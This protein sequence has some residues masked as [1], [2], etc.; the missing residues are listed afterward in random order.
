MLFKKVTEN[1][2]I[3]S[4]FPTSHMQNLNSPVKLADSK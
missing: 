4:N 2:D 1:K 3:A